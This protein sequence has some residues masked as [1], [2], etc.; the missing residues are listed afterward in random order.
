MNTTVE[1]TSKKIRVVCERPAVDTEVTVERVD[2]PDDVVRKAE[3]RPSDFALMRP[4]NESRFEQGRAIWNDV[5]DGDK[6][7]LVP[8]STVGASWWS[9]LLGMLTGGTKNQLS[10]S[11]AEVNGWK[12]I[13]ATIRGAGYEGY[14]WAHGY[15]WR[16]EAIRKL[17][18]YVDL[19]IWSPPMRSIRESSYSACFH[20]TGTRNR[21]LVNVNDGRT[22][23]KIRD[24]N[25][26]VAAVNQM[27]SE[28][29]R[30]NRAA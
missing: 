8:M 5:E 4:N 13:G 7:H 25:S 6:V 30:T 17:D 14:F 22:H 15:R 16:G 18:G 24:L 27:I 29:F 12:R 9:Y 23:M 19:F 26:G 11:F 1:A 2:T 3:Q 28:V 21:W 10:S 20:P